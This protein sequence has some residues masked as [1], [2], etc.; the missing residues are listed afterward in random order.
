LS[1]PFDEQKY[2][3]LL[4]GLEVTEMMFSKIDLGDRYDAEYFDKQDLQVEYLL[5]SS[6]SVK[7]GTLGTFVASAFY[8]AA[9]QLYEFGDTPFIRCVDCI[10]YPLIT[11]EQNDS[12]EKIP[13]IFVEENKGVNMLNRWDM[14]ITKVGTPCFASL[15]FEHDEVALSRTV[16]GIKDIRNI[17]PF[18]LLV[19]LRSKYGFSQLQRERE[20]TIQYQLTLERVKKTLVYIPPIKFQDKVQTMIENHIDCIVQSKTLYRQA[21]E[22]L[23]ETIGLKD[24]QPS[25]TGTNIKNFKESFLA[26]GRLDAEYYQ[27]KY[28]EIENRI[29]TQPYS[30]VEKEFDINKNIVDYSAKQYNYIEIGDINVGNGAYNYN[31]IEVS[32]LP[33]NAKIQSK[34]GD[35]LISKVRPN[36][37]AVSIIRENISNLVVSGA[38]TVLEEKA[39]Y[40]KE[41]LFVLLRTKNYREWLLKYN[42]GTSYPVI[43]DEDIL[44]L[45]IPL[46]D[47]EIQ[48]QIAELIEKSFY[49]RRESERLL[50]EAKEM[51][52]KEI[53]KINDIQ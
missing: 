29:K 16:L 49:L 27:P 44:N 5:K 14:V 20:L 52:E 32:E 8:P 24:F 36:R 38:F 33:A 22:L 39:D 10:N 37:G 26:T 30:F 19:F 25:Q 42:V 45:P 2:K 51:V 34:C 13:Q 23:L 41:V 43:K 47:K 3:R 50:E 48:C 12:F 9:T 18:Y 4:E 40:K 7:L 53:E 1:S 31:L 17:N 28:E 11:K 21:E 46:I 6:N 35:M 15:V